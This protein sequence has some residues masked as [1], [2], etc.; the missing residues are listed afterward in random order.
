HPGGVRCVAFGPDGRLASGGMDSRVRFWDLATGRQL[1]CLE[2]HKGPVTTLAFSPDGSQFASGGED[3]TIRIRDTRS[4]KLDCEL[5]ERTRIQSISFGGRERLASVSMDHNVKVWD[6][7]TGHQLVTLREEENKVSVVAF[8]LDGSW[9]ASGSSSQGL[10][11]HDARPETVD[12][13]DEHEALGLL[14]S[15]FN[16]SVPLPSIPVRIQEDGRIRDA[17]RRRALEL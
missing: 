5:R 6:T 9:L 16:Q 17:V 8:S 12:L 2:E 1:L 11:L 4:G 10:Q 3:E 15:L 14:E 13:A 7:K